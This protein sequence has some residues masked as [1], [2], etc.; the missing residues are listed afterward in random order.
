MIKDT[1][2]VTATGFIH[3]VYWRAGQIRQPA[4]K[5]LEALLIAALIYLIVN[6]LIATCDLAFFAIS[7][8][9]IGL[10]PIR[11]KTELV[12]TEYRLAPTFLSQP[13]PHKNDLPKPTVCSLHTSHLPNL[14]F[15]ATQH[16]ISQY[17]VLK[18]SNLLHCVELQHTLR[19]GQSFSKPWQS[20]R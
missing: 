13:L 1:T 10:F 15:P 17:I 11:I 3:D 19:T 4:F 2:L 20:V 8:D 5:N 14:C 7:L 12:P 16:T 18:C 6:V 9:A